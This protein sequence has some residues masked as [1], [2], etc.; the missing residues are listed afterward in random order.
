MGVE[1]MRTIEKIRLVADVAAGEAE[2]TLRLVE[3]GKVLPFQVLVT[4]KGPTST[5]AKGLLA[6][7][8]S[9]ADGREQYDFHVQEAG[10]KGWAQAL[11][12]RAKVW[13]GVPAPDGTM[14]DGQRALPVAPMKRKPGRPRKQR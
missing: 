9:E 7:V 11:P 8:N 5:L 13:T 3:K 6:A 10:K 2:L 1:R 12:G 14:P 4:H